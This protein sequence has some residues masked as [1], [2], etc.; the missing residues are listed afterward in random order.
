VRLVVF[1][2]LAGCWTTPEPEGPGALLRRHHAA[3]DVYRVCMRGDGTMTHPEMKDPINVTIRNIYDER[4]LGVRGHEVELRAETVAASARMTVTGHEPSTVDVANQESEPYSI[5]DRNRI[6]GVP[7]TNMRTVDTDRVNLSFVIYVADIMKIEF[8]EGAVHE[9][10]TF[11]LKVRRL[12][13]HDDSLPAK[14]AIDATFTVRDVTAQYVDLDCKGTHVEL[15]ELGEQRAGVTND[16]TCRAR[17]DRRDG[18]TSRWSIDATGSTTT[19]PD[20]EAQ[21]HVHSHYDIAVGGVDPAVCE[22]AA[23]P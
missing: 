19:L 6:V 23:A 18:H 13:P 20:A 3:G 1:I 2:V 17:I 9:Q 15:T 4:V 22:R 16:F 12:I 7:I 5:D 10:D 14:L 11:P 21:M 8:P